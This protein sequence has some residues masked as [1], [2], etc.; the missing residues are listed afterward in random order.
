MKKLLIAPVRLYQKLI[1]PL[2]P[3]SCR[4]HPTCSNYM[5]EAIEKHGLL[6]LLMG[7]AR[8]LR[9]HPFV[10]DGDDPVPDHFSLRRNHKSQK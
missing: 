4:Y 10:E 5:V 6:G 9:C 7:I 2:T 1:S 3:A 8:I